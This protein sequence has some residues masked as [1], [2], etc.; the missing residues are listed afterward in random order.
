MSTR[1]GHIVAIAGDTVQVRFSRATACGQCRARP[2][3]STGTQD[4]HDLVLPLPPPD[5]AAP[6]GHDRPGPPHALRVGDRVAVAV[7]HG[8][9]LRGYALAYGLPL[10]GLLGAMALGSALAWPDAHTALAS[11]GGLA[12]GFGLLRLVAARPGAA[13]QARLVPTG[14][15]SPSVPPP[16]TD[17]H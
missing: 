2:V 17:C 16:S 14:D 9:L 12:A 15:P 1:H 11:L 7:P 5:T 10:L 6:D 4:G 8:A 3:C 13:P